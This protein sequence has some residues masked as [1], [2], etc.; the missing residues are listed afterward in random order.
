[1]FG[2]C[3]GCCCSEIKVT[4]THLSGEL[5]DKGYGVFKS[6]KETRLAKLSGGKRNGGYGDPPEV[7]QPPGDGIVPQ[8]GF[9]MV[10]V[11]SSDEPTI[12]GIGHYK[13]ITIDS[14]RKEQI[15]AIDDD[16]GVELEKTL[17]TYLPVIIFYCSRKNRYDVSC[18]NIGYSILVNETE[19]H[20]PGNY[21]LP[22]KWFS[23][24]IYRY[25][26]LL[27]PGAS[28]GVLVFE[29]IGDRLKLE[30]WVAV[31]SGY[32]VGVTE[33]RAVDVVG[34]E[35]GDVDAGKTEEFG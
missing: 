31:E 6:N 35:E 26:H 27:K 18:K 2:S 28:D 16:D 33:E 24:S 19:C 12:D 14:S 10:P 32:D 17:K 7:W 8:P 20:A 30:V 5:V 13:R 11:S 3:H 4:Q 22:E 25:H 23:D 9:R 21:H 34:V 1:M 15:N 29:S